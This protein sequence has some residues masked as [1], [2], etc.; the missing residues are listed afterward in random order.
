MN[1]VL[2]VCKN[3]ITLFF[4][5]EQP[6]ASNTHWNDQRFGREKDR[7]PGKFIGSNV[8]IFCYKELKKF[9]LYKSVSQ[10]K[11]TF[12]VYSDPIE[13]GHVKINFS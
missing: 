3:V 12:V 2:Q 10:S 5:Q 7:T 9:A 1:Q 11:A 8:V 13:S 6:G 4:F